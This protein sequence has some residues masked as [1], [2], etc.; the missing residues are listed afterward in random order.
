[1]IHIFLLYALCFSDFG[2][3][4]GVEALGVNYGQ[5]GNNLLPPQDVLALLNSLE[6]TKTRIYDTNPQVLTAFAN[7]GIELIVTVENEILDD[8]MDPQQALQWV[9]THIKP[10]F[11]ATRIT[12]ISV[13]NE[14]FTSSDSSVI[15]NVVPAM[16]S[17]HGA[18]V[19]LGLDS[20]IQVSTASSLGVLANSFP[21]SAGCF[22]SDLAGVMSQFL[23]FL[24]NTKAPF[25][26]NAY[27]YF[28]YKDDPNR[29]PLDYVLFNPNPGMVDPYTKLNYDNMLYAQVDAV[30]FAV[31]RMGFGGMEVRV[32]ETGWPSK[33][34]PNE[35]GATLQNAATY[36]TNL[37]RRQMKNEGTPLR[38]GQRLEVYVF[39]LF[40]EDMKPGPTSE[41]NYGLY[42]PDGTMAY[43][44]GI[45]AL[46]TTPSSTSS[47]SIP[48]SLTPASISLTSSATQAK[49][50]RYESL[51]YW[52]FVYLL[53]F[54]VLMRR[55]F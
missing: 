40:N 42:K 12:G 45:S 11:P 13:G 46:S 27:P 32:S 30:I 26:I 2:L 20:Y 41:R 6:I 18:L 7:T 48:S 49:A 52:I 37:L 54:Q 24:W 25:W 28:A 22:R 3:I 51:E 47:S 15:A 9:T 16:V 8:M 50:S 34:D 5:I 36:N 10:Y 14:V 17:I 43:N 21:P 31:S 4:H 29:I 33:G 39:A 23:H 1:M 44:L 19:Q 53:T 55:P 35:Y 38:P